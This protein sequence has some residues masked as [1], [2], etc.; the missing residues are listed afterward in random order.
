[1]GAGSRTESDGERPKI[2][3]LGNCPHFL[4]PLQELHYQEPQEMWGLQKPCPGPS[5]AP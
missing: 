2:A 3:I 5:P 1:M 4:S